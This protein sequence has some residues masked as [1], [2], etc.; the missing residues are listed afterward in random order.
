MISFSLSSG[1]DSVEQY[2]KADCCWSS[3]K[4]ST[5]GSRLV[6]KIARCCSNA[7]AAACKIMKVSVEESDG[8]MS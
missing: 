1:F 4:F 2:A 5:E 6:M 3:M 7:N 8:T